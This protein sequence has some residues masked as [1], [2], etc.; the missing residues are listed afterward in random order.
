MP[1]VDPTSGLE[2]LQNIGSSSSNRRTKVTPLLSIEEVK[3]LGSKASTFGFH[4]F[5]SYYLLD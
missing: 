3:D 2:L 5:K 4:I 1:I